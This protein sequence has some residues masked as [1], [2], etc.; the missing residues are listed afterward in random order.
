MLYKFIVKKKQ[1]FWKQID[2][3]SNIRKIPLTIWSSIIFIFDYI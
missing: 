1:I 3:F 2:D